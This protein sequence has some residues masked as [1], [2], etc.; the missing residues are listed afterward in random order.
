MT[1]QYVVKTVKKRPKKL[2][3]VV[4][5]H[6]FRFFCYIIGGA[7]TRTGGATPIMEG[8]NPTPSVT[9]GS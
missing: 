7:T 2:Y 5:S 3:I 9:V 4:F 1:P 6:L 8:N